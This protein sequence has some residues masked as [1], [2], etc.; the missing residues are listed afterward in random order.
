MNKQ[1]PLP[2]CQFCRA[3]VKTCFNSLTPAK[4][5]LNATRLRPLCAAI[6]RAIVVLPHPGG[7]HKTSEDSRPPTNILLK[8]PSGPRSA[9]CPT[10][11][12]S[13]FGRNLP[14]GR[15]S[16]EKSQISSDRWL[17]AFSIPKLVNSITRCRPLR[18]MVRRQFLGDLRNIFRKFQPS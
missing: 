12:S 14:M 18:F 4:I 2:F 11:S 7:P 17:H 1:V 16:T 6:K 13:V 15:A 9:A 10:T 5:A 8:L 3:C